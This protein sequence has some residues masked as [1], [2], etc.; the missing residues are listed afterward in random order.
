ML[1]HYGRNIDYLRISVTDRCNLRCVYCMP[2]M[3]IKNLK[4]EDILSYKEILTVVKAASKL[5][6]RK[7]KITGGEPLLRKGIVNLVRSIKAVKGIEQ[8][9]MTTN[10][11]LLG[12]MAEEL[13]HAEL[14]SVNISI[15]SLNITSFCRITRRD[16]FHKV[17]QGLRKPVEAGLKT[18]INCVPI[19]ELNGTDLMG[20][21]DIAWL[22]PVDIRF[23]ELMPV[24]LGKA[25]T[26]VPNEKIF[27]EIEQCFGTLKPS[28]KNHGNGPAKYYSLEGYKGSIGF[29]SAITN[30]FCGDCNRIRFTADGDLKLCLHYNKGIAL[31]PLLRNG[32]S[33]DRLK[34]IM[35]DAIYNKP[36]H[37]GFNGDNTEN[38]DMRKMVQI[39]G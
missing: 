25:Y 5:G 17:L 11:I 3:E 8:V 38:Q 12:E 33:R 1:D 16:C 14:I 7:I 31:K 9:T 35:G 4:H 30:E 26:P 22:Y 27:K 36:E 29:I 18:K 34:K 39:G 19:K 2:E 32:I 24:G 13:F 15:D 6:I 10:G 20:L 23:I 37:H 21:L 28:E